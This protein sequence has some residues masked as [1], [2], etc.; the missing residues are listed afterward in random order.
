MLDFRGRL[1]PR[2]SYRLPLRWVMMTIAAGLLAL[3]LWVTRQ[4]L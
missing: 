3:I 4:V 2:R 1:F